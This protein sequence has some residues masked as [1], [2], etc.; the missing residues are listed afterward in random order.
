AGN[1]KD[2]VIVTLA[3]SAVIRAGG[4]VS[5]KCGETLADTK[6]R[7][8]RSRS[9]ASSCHPCPERRLRL[10]RLVLDFGELGV[11]HVIGLRRF[12]AGCPCLATRRAGRRS[13]QLLGHFFER[14]GL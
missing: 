14:L 5:R 12:T 9:P 7:K 3:H 6:R 2:F 11:N 10:L 1:T 13:E 8:K 4:S